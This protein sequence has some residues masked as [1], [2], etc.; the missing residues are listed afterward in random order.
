LD[1]DLAQ[2]IAFSGHA[3]LTEHEDPGASGLEEA[4][5]TLEAV[6]IRAPFHLDP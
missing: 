1:G 4:D 6:G 3:F 2:A 5:R